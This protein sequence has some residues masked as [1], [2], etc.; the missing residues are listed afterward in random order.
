MLCA[1]HTTPT[2]KLLYLHV[3]RQARPPQRVDYLAPKWETALSVFPKDTATRYRIGSRTKVSQPSVF[4]G[5]LYREY[6][7]FCQF[8]LCLSLRIFHTAGFNFTDIQKTL[9]TFFTI[10]ERYFGEPREIRELYVGPGFM[11]RM[12]PKFH[13]SFWLNSCSK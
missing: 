13:K 3:F 5:F 1:C 2:Q 9:Y 4:G 10:G 12:G 6:P 7:N 8:H 11:G